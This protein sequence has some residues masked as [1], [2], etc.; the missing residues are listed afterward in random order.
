[1]N[2]TKVRSG[3]VSSN[4]ELKNGCLVSSSVDKLTLGVWLDEWLEVYK[5]GKGATNTYSSYSACIR[6]WIGDNLKKTHLKKVRHSVLQKAIN[7][8]KSGTCKIIRTVLQQS[9]TMATKN[10]YI[11]NNPAI[12]LTVP[13]INKKKVTPL[14]DEEV[15]KLLI[16]RKN[17]RN[18][19]YYLLSV[20][21]GARIGEVLGLSWDDIDFKNNVIHIRHSLKVNKITNKHEIGATKTGKCRDVP[22][23]PKV[24]SAI[25]QHKIKQVEEKLQIGQSYNSNNMVFCDVVGEYLKLKYMYDELKKTIKRLKVGTDV[26]P[27]TLRHTFVSQMISAGNT[28]IALISNIVGHTDITTTLKTYSHLMPNDTQEAFKALEKHMQNIAI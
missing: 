23:L 9:L 16:D 19:L 21:T 7:D 6:L 17:T 13:T 27:H 14:T 5:K 25:K 22:L 10:K 26:T 24:A 20:Y 3:N 4:N 11:I 12:G 2:L 1:M 28:S 18:Y 8:S 15:S